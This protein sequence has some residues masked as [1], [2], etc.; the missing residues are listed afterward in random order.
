MP[1]T[2]EEDEPT[3]AFDP[4]HYPQGVNANFKKDDAE[5]LRSTYAGTSSWLAPDATSWRTG[6]QHI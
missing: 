2:G 1:S 5:G 4:T 3:P 6:P